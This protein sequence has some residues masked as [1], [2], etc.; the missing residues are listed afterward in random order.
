MHTPWCTEDAPEI[1]T[2]TKIEI[3]T[4]LIFILILFLRKVKILLDCSEE[5]IK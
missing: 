2:P 3:L 5:K 1:P 4:H